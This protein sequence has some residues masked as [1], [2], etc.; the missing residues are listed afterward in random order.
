MAAAEE[1]DAIDLSGDGGVT[2]V[3]LEEGGG[4]HPEPLRDVCVVR[5][6]GRLV[7]GGDEFEN[8]GAYPARFVLG[9]G[10][11]LPC[12]DMAVGEMRVGGRARVRSSP[13]YAFGRKGRDPGVPGNA[14]VE[15]V[16]E[17]VEARN[18]SDLRNA[19]LV[20]QLEED[21]EML[22]E[23][24]RRRQLAARRRAAL[25]RRRKAQ[26]ARKP[27]RAALLAEK[28]AAKKSGKVKNGKKVLTKKEKKE[29]KAAEAAAKAAKKE[30]LR[31]E[32]ERHLA[33]AK[34]A[35]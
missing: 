23:I 9:E 28:L 8:S 21:A 19:D 35:E 1:P 18:E 4:A 5:F 34:A 33:A 27:D 26:A 14:T 17:L 24:K 15:Y 2:V 29:R 25:E 3:H 30:E 10:S 31:L 22:E 6:V 7:P 13:E 32:R 20:A 11:V 12:W 16:L